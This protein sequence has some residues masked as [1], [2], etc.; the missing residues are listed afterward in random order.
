MHHTLCALRSA[1]CTMRY[2]L[3]PL[4]S[5]ICH[6]PSALCRMKLVLRLD[7]GR[8]SRILRVWEIVKNRDLSPDDRKG[9]VLAWLYVG[10]HQ[11]E[12]QISPTSNSSWLSPSQSV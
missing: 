12:G 10:G 6:L 3:C 7:V 4:S 9:I 1:L 8:W 11:V 2:A 5:V